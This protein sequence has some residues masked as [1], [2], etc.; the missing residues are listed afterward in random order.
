MPA[1]MRA[2]PA[3]APSRSLDW[4]SASAWRRDAEAIGVLLTAIAGARPGSQGL[5]PLTCLG[6]VA[7]IAAFPV[8]LGIYRQN[9][10]QDD[11]HAEL[12][13]RLDGQDE[14]LKSF[15]E[16]EE[17]AAVAD[18]EVAAPASGLESLTP[19]QRDAIESKYGEGST[20]AAWK[21]DA[22][23]GNRARLVRLNDGRIVSV[24]SGDARAASTFTRSST[25][26]FR[27]I[28]RRAL[29]AVAST[30]RYRTGT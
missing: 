22:G 9:R 4:P 12:L 29:D 18:G 24:Y 21:T 8:A 19:A 7:T 6:T 26:R 28:P 27:L 10:Q 5:N 2:L 30:A 25:D 1:R 15:A 20:A 14:L 16:H 11:A 13:D 23:R 3:Q 17:P